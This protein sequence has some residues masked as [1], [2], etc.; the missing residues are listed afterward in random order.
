MIPLYLILF[1]LPTA[2]TPSRDTPLDA[3]ISTVE[4]TTLDAQITSIQSDVVHYRLSNRDDQIQIADVERILFSRPSATP[5]ISAGKSVCMFHF[6]DGSWLEGRLLPPRDSADKLIH[7]D[8]G[9]AQPLSFRLDALAAV[10]FGRNEHAAAEAEFNTRLT[11]RDPGRD[12]LIVPQADKA[13]VLPGALEGLRPDQWTFRIGDKLQTAALDKAFGVVLGG[14]E[15]PQTEGNAIIEL[16]GHR[17]I[18]AR[19][20]SADDVTLRLESS[21]FGSLDLPWSDVTSISLRSGRVVYLS[22]LEAAKT[23]QRSVFDVAWPPRRD[24]NVTGGPLVIDQR[25]YSKGLGVHAYSALTYNVGGKFDRLVATIGVDDSAADGASAVF[26]VRGDDRMLFESKALTSR[27]S[28]AVNV[29]LR[30]V[31]QLTLECDGGADIDLA[32]HGDWAEAR[33]IRASPNRTH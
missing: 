10:Q 32:D 9:W 22:D 1:C 17:R 27:R 15:P 2:D 29:E 4:G 19:I 20:K 31:R 18:A 33:L 23:V 24:T 3:N 26:R 30:G 16:A 8:V 13:V 21:A 7:V 5:R 12:L 11:H 28:E 6:A 25:R 14:D